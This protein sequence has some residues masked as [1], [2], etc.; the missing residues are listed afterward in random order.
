M[1]N[2]IQIKRSAGNAAPGAADLSKGELAWVDHGTG[3]GD[4]V[5]YIGDMTAAGA[6]TRVIGGTADSDYISGILTSTALT[7]VP[8]APTAA[9]GTS[10]TQL[11]TTAFVANSMTANQNPISQAGDTNIS[12]SQSAGH[13]LIWDG[14]DTLSLIH[15]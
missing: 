3:G 1:A 5:L 8:T 13:V 11:A 9:N 10:T 12:G 6:V 15:I 14:V 2:T 7:G 4:G